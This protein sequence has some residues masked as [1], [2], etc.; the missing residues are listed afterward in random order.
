MRA[1]L[2]LSTLTLLGLAA[3]GR[4]G[5]PAH[6]RDD[7]PRLE[8]V[9]AVQ[10]WYRSPTSCGQGPYELELPVAGARWGEDFE[11]RVRAPR[12]VELHAIVLADDDEVARASGV[13]GAGGA[14]GAAAG[15]D[16]VADNAR[17]ADARERLG[18]Q[19][20]GGG[21]GGAGGGAASPPETRLEARPAATRPPRTP[22]RRPRRPRRRPP[23]SSTRVW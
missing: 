22:R 7:E 15:G 10:Q 11:L 20:G 21:G 19:R 17:C 9:V 4:G 6:P 3:C 1:V 2:L 8:P 14:G 23:S 18:L 5:H 13:F 12:A 16:R